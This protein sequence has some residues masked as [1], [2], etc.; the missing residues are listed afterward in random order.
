MVLYSI[1]EGGAANSSWFCLLSSVRACSGPLY[2]EPCMLL[3]SVFRSFWPWT[4]KLLQSVFRFFTLNLLGSFRACSGFLPWTFF[5][6]FIILSL[7]RSV[8]YLE[9]FSAISPTIRFP[10]WES[11]L[12]DETGNWFCNTWIFYTKKHVCNT[13]QSHHFIPARLPHNMSYYCLLV[14]RGRKD[15]MLVCARTHCLLLLA[16]GGHASPRRGR[17]YSLTRPLSGSFSEHIDADVMRLLTIA[18]ALSISSVRGN[19]ILGIDVLNDETGKRFCNT[20][21]V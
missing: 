1:L 13:Y 17:A 7:F 11:V 6:H 21:S 10:M 20:D 8:F 16:H 19:I 14:A 4:F 12:N 9:P 5:T 15:R 18:K 3:Q 2:L